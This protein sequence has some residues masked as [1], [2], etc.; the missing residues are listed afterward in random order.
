MAGRYGLNNLHCVGVDDADDAFR[1]GAGNIKTSRPCVDCQGGRFAGN[2]GLCNDRTLSSVDCHDLFRIGHRNEQAFAIGR[3]G[4]GHWP[5]PAWFLRV[6]GPCVCCACQD[7]NKHRREQ[8][9]EFWKL[10]QH[11][12]I[13]RR[14]SS[15]GECAS[16]LTSMSSSRFS[17][18]NGLASNAVAP[19]ARSSSTE[20]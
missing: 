3:C 18:S 19:L 9:V 8:S 4:H 13:P 20:R 17:K 12:Q 5:K 16:C 11:F 7:G 6:R 15:A 2:I 10:F 14:E 1:A